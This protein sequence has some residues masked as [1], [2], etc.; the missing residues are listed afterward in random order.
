MRIILILISKIFSKKINIFPFLSDIDIRYIPSLC[1]Q[2]QIIEILIKA[3]FLTS[4]NLIFELFRSFLFVVLSLWTKPGT[5]FYFESTPV[6]T[7]HYLACKSFWQQMPVLFNKNSQHTIDYN[8]NKTAE[9][10]NSKSKWSSCIESFSVFSWTHLCCF[11]CLPAGK[12]DMVKSKWGLALAAVV[13]VLSS[14]LMSVGLCTLFGLTPTLNGG[15]EFLLSPSVFLLL[16]GSSP[17]SLFFSLSEYQQSA[18][19]DCWGFEIC[20]LP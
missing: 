11:L 14:L 19:R 9:V 12:I 1:F 7:F 17:E 16:F 18:E 5:L 15:W 3:S 20:F 4:F 2:L 8:S 10:L 13:T 6:V